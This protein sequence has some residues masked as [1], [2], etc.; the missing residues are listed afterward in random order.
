M[1]AAIFTALLLLSAVT[2]ADRLP[3]L[4]DLV[5]AK[6]GDRMRIEDLKKEVL[7]LIASDGIEEVEKHYLSPLIDRNTRQLA[8][9]IFGN[10]EQNTISGEWFYK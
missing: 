4:V 5:A 10:L 8:R 1:K 9:E 2:L 6:Y 7:A 3:P